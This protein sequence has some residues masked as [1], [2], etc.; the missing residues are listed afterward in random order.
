M[1]DGGVNGFDYWRVYFSYGYV[2]SGKSYTGKF[3]V[4]CISEDS[5]KDAEANISRG[6]AIVHYDR[7]NPAKSVLWQ[8][9]V[10]KLY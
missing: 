1:I 7:S 3:H 9:E 2:V 6:E 4:N 5:G 8:N 10:E